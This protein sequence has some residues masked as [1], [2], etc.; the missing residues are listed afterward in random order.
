[1]LFA[2]VGAKISRWQRWLVVELIISATVNMVR[3]AQNALHTIEWGVAN[4]VR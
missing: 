4:G 1:M 2:R 3:S